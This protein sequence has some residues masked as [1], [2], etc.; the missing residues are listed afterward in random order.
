MRI[1]F[2][3]VLMCL[4]ST[5]SVAQVDK[6]QLLAEDVVVKSH[7]MDSL[8]L[9][10]E[11]M[12][13]DS[14]DIFFMDTV[15]QVNKELYSKNASQLLMVHFTD[16]ELQ[17]LT[18]FYSSEIGATIAK[19]MPYYQAAMGKILENLIIEKSKELTEE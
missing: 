1:L 8:E 9:V 14:E 18:D 12:Q 4:V 5:V 11:S 15:T 13:K 3:T 19:K 16:D 10:I 2:L 17:A 6:K 7:M